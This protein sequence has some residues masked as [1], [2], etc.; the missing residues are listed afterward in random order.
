MGQEISQ[1]SG[2][3]DHQVA[4]TAIEPVGT[5][6]A[7]AI[8]TL[9][10]DHLARLECGRRGGCGG[11]EVELIGAGQK[12]VGSDEGTIASAEQRL[13]HGRNLLAHQAVGEVRGRLTI[14]GTD[15]KWSS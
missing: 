10:I 8:G 14:D 11:I 12:E 1:R 15:G 3:G 9:L 2:A 6:D 4:C 7:G 13:L 5:I